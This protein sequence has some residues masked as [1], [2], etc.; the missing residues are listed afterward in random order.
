MEKAITL[1]GET[2]PPIRG[3]PR[4]WYLTMALGQLGETDKAWQYYEKLIEEMWA[5]PSAATIR[6][7]AEAAEILG[8]NPWVSSGEL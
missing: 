1:R 8:E 5:N 3:G 6:Y 7:Q 4:W 2:E